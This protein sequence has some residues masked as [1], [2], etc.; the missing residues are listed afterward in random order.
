MGKA[1][2]KLAGWHREMNFQFKKPVYFGDK[3][4]CCFTITELNPEIEPKLRRCSKT[5]RMRLS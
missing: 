5:G 2:A 3:I 4:E 1:I